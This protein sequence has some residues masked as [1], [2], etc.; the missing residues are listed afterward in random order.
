[1]SVHSQ[2]SLS[3]FLPLPTTDVR[4]FFAA[5]AGAG[6]G[7]AG[8]APAQEGVVDNLTKTVKSMFRFMNSLT[9]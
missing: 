2:H 9:K 7:A 5:Q 8:E 1:M 3:G 4:D 6:N